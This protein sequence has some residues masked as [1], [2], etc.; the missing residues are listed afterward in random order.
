MPSQLNVNQF[1]CGQPQS[2]KRAEAPL[3]LLRGDV[4]I[5]TTNGIKARSIARLIMLM[6]MIPSTPSLSCLESVIACF[7]ARRDYTGWETMTT[8]GFDTISKR[9]FEEVLGSLFHTKYFGIM[10]ER[11]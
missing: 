9:R 10:E 4:T 11:L 2:L 8:P 6:M 7:E 5:D 1:L 3:Q